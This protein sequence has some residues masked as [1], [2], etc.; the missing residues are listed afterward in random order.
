MEE[1]RLFEEQLVS[2][3]LVLPQAVW[4][5]C[6]SLQFDLLNGFVFVDDGISVRIQFH[7]L[8][9][10]RFLRTWVFLLHCCQSQLVVDLIL[11][12]LGHIG[13]RSLVHI[14]YNRFAARGVL[15]GCLW[16]SNTASPHACLRL[17][18]LLL[19]DVPVVSGDQIEIRLKLM[20]LAVK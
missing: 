18:L 10:L 13:A 17:E 6:F 14:R 11:D 5:V 1:L 2:P 15:F 9:I 3:D 20:E 16:T 8:R 12:R 19:H 7:L 4:Q